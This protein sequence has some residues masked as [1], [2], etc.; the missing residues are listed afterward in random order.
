MNS[1]TLT[2]KEVLE[3]LREA[4][5]AMEPVTGRNYFLY[6]RKDG[7]FFISLIEPI[8]WFRKFELRFVTNVE[9]SPDNGWAITNKKKA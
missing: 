5:V 4:Q 1:D 6:E 8:Y 3:S 9:W 7:S 2:E